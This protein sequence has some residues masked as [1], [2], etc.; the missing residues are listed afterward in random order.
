[1]MGDISLDLFTAVFE[2]VPDLAVNLLNRDYTVLWANSVMALKVGRSV[3]DL[4]GQPCYR[5][6]RWREEPC[7]ECLLD[8]V[9]RTR[10]P[11]KMERWLDLPNKER[12]YGEVRAY[13]IFDRDGSM[14]HVF[15]LITDLTAVKRDEEH[16]K[17]YIES[18]E[19]T[20]RNLTSEDVEEKLKAGM[21][22]GEATLTLRENEVIRLLAR[23]YSNKE[24]ARILGISIDTAKTHVRNIFYKL[25]VR[26]RTSAAVWASSRKLI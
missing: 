18:L 14:K 6:F 16:R 3:N 19:E 21:D 20:L 22:C 8:I 5:A 9:S 10:K 15:E 7:V 2:K 23:G 13:P 4:V 26:D 17:R 12:R 24:I 1:M 11:L 25:N